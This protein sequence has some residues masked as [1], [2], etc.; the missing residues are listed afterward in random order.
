MAADDSPATFLP[1]TTTHMG[2]PDPLAMRSTKPVTHASCGVD[3]FQDMARYVADAS[4]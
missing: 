2:E 4:G 3:L 1:R